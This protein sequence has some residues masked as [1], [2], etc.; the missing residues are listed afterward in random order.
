M[1]SDIT[2][3]NFRV[4]DEKG[5]TFKIRPITILTGKNSC[6][7]SSVVKGIEL[8][9]DS[10]N[11]ANNIESGDNYIRRQFSFN[12]LELN[13]TKYPAN[14]MGS[15]SKVI[16]N[17]SKSSSLSF[18]YTHSFCN[19][20]FDVK[21]EYVNGALNNGTIS[22]TEIRSVNFDK[23]FY[24]RNVKETHFDYTAIDMNTIVSYILDDYDKYLDRYYWYSFTKRQIKEIKNTFE[25]DFSISNIIKTIVNI[26][27]SEHKFDTF[28]KN[29]TNSCQ[30]G[31]E[32]NYGWDKLQV[33]LQS[34]LN[35]ENCSNFK[36]YI[37]AN[38][39][40]IIRTN[41][42]EEKDETTKEKFLNSEITLFEI[43]R[44][45][46]H[47][48]TNKNLCNF[49]D[50]IYGITGRILFSLFEPEFIKCSFMN[51]WPAIKRLYSFDDKDFASM[52]LHNYY[53]FYEIDNKK[54]KTE[55]KKVEDF[56]NKWLSSD[57]FNIAT[58]YK[59]EPDNEGLGVKVYLKKDENT[60]TLLADEGSGITQLFFLLLLIV[61]GKEK[62]TI[63]IE[64][65]EIHFHPAFQSKLAELIVDAHKVFNVDFIIETHSAYLIRKMQNLVVD[66][67]VNLSTE[68]IIMYYIERGQDNRVQKREITIDA[69]NGNISND[70][71]EGFLDEESILYLERLELLAK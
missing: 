31:S 55:T 33:K 69:N 68:D 49:L 1:N 27:D 19:T 25:N 71:G 61:V 70:F 2:F 15:F 60:K 57:K 24:Q 6:G 16:N 52:L 54:T 40:K 3:K 18:T 23:P 21:I 63:L 58:G 44:F 29:L 5:E 17:K 51:S 32:N 65:P 45:L 53:Q 7:K 20:K 64:E 30:S 35:K 41:I 12:Q 14:I 28:N 4:F 50:L 34:H 62:N 48:C 38:L 47:I 9:S 10:L 37:E 36:D 26:L 43:I 46:E 59:I 39:A 22:S 13:F 66:K 11:K 8:L 56:I 67:S 42:K